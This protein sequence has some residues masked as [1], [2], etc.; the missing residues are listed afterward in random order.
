MAPYQITQNH[1]LLN[2]MFTLE[3]RDASVATLLETIL[4][5]VLKA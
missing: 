3:S 1:Q 5:Q 4:N 2:S